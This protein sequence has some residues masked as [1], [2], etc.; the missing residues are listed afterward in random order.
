MINLEPDEEQT[1]VGALARS[2]GEK[3]LYPAA[4]DAEREGAVPKDVWHTVFE[5]GLAMPVPEEHGGGGVPGPLAQLAA[6]EN[7]A[8]G[9]PGIALAAL[10]NGAAAMLIAEHGTPEQLAG[11]VRLAT[12]PEARSAVA[13][14]EGF[15][16]GPGE[17]ATEVH[18]EGDTVRVVGRKVGVAFAAVSDPLV[19]VGRDQVT[20]DVRAVLLTSADEGVTVDPSP[21]ALALEAAQVGSVTIDARV[22]VSALVGGPGADGARLASTLQRLRLQTAAAAVGT[23]QRAVEYAASYATTRIAFGTPIA[24]FQGVTFPLA[25][26]LMR[27]EAARLELVAATVAILDDPSADHEDAVAQA[28]GYA[29]SVGAQSTRDSVQT[30]G[31]HGFI[32]DHPVELWYRSAATL[33]ALDSDPARGAFQAAL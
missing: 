26:A 17:Y 25:E 2:I 32:R 11:L 9:D 31:G 4:R 21:G 6:A 23:A 10:W 1:E 30:L 24:S 15:G 3:V 33:S 22:P 5:T 20:G 14:H 7:L 18:V 16:R 28:V 13:Y 8:H 29:L 27:I 19:V 12:D